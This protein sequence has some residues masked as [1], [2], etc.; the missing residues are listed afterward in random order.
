M[1]LQ[2]RV[3]LHW[4]V[5]SGTSV[6]GIS[7]RRSG[8][9]PWTETLGGRLVLG[10]RTCSKGSSKY[11]NRKPLTGKR[12]TDGSTTRCD[13]LNDP[14]VDVV[15]YQTRDLFLPSPTF[16]GSCNPTR[17]VPSP[18]RSL[19]DGEARGRTDQV[20][21]WGSSPDVWVIHPRSIYKRIIHTPV[22]TPR[23]APIFL[24]SPRLQL[25]RNLLIQVSINFRACRL[26][27]HQG[28]A[29]KRTDVTE[30]GTVG[31]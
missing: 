12:R 27:P 3:L 19:T 18:R 14:S 26:P 7:Y 8:S 29:G 13:T 23:P 1:W 10:P 6:T 16:R 5:P 9:S 17:A 24:S 21:T 30:G 20:S 2:L 15:T 11:P 4:T 28:S 31:V 25:A 22:S